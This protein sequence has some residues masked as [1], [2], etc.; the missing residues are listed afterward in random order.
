MGPFNFYS[1]KK[2]RF[3]PERLEKVSIALSLFYWL[4]FETHTHAM[5][6][7]LKINKTQGSNAHL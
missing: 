2:A 3:F 7:K 1:I 4:W 5:E 6:T